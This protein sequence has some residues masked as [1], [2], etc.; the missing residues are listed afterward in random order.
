MDLFDVLID[1]GLE[2]WDKAEELISKHWQAIGSVGSISG[3]AVL[4][5]K[6]FEKKTF[7]AY[8]DYRISDEYSPRDLT[9]HTWISGVQG[10]GK[11]NKC[12]RIFI[13]SFIKKGWGG[14]YID[15]HGTA[16]IIMQSIPPDR[17]KD[18]IYLAPWMNRLYGI[19]ILHRYSDDEGEVDKIAEDVVDV[20]SKM[21]PRSWGDKLANCIRLATKAVL[22]AEENNPDYNNPT[23]IDVYKTL[24]M[25]LFREYILKYVD[26][27]IITDF[28]ETLKGTSAIDKLVNPLS[29]STV[30]LFLC[31]KNGINLLK[32]MN[33]KKIIIANLDNEHLSNNGNLL[34]AMLISILAKCASKRKEN[35]ELSSPYFAIAADEFYEYANKHISTLIAQMRKKNVCMILANQYRD[36]M[37]KDV[38]AAISMCQFKFIHTPA[39]EDLNWVSNL[40]KDFFTKEQIIKLPFYAC[41]QDAHNPGKPRAPFIT[42]VAP[43]IPDYNWEYVHKLKYASLSKAP[44]RYKLIEEMS[45]DMAFIGVDETNDDEIP[46]GEIMIKDEEPINYDE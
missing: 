23:L 17:W 11:S 34:A 37:P 12:R 3:A 41:I 10:T 2:G 29:S 19:N 45:K 35:D 1:L 13:N 9:K 44:Y 40:Y 38:Q 42:K 18:V 25:P 22:I 33:Q 39:D 14:I 27:E 26:N 24:K 20:F 6:V 5:H 31:Q 15:T 46:T 28:F 32:A 7:R 36:Q 8:L 16:D 30:L 4:S 43:F 21:Y